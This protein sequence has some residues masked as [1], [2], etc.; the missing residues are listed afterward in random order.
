[1]ALISG[2]LSTNGRSLPVTHGPWPARRRWQTTRMSLIAGLRRNDRQVALPALCG[3]Y[4]APLYALIRART[5]CQPADADDAVQGFLTSTMRP[6]FF[7][8]FDPARGRFRSWLGKA[9]HRFFLNKNRSKTVAVSLDHDAAEPWRDPGAKD[10][11]APAAEREVD[12]AQ[13]GTVLQRALERLRQSYAAAHQEDLFEELFAAVM[14]ER[15]MTDDAARAKLV[16]RS[17]SCLKQEK[18]REKT[19]W[20]LAY[21]GCVREEL[22]AL[23]F[24]RVDMTR[25]IAEMADALR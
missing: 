3:A 11:A 9:A 16:H 8:T 13:I 25:I 10:D 14:G 15:R 5:G 6:G 19:A 23:G 12:R 17:A 2:A 4:W 22:A 21:R 24:K 7:Q 1:M 20:S 18:H